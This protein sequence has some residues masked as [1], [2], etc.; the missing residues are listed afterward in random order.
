V[1]S[2]QPEGADAIEDMAKYLVIWKQGD[3]GMW[4]L[5]VDIWNS[6]LPAE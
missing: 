4:R 5:H 3:D 6:S 1:V 2:I